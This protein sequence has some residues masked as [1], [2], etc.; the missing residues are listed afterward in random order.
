M[1]IMQKIIYLI[2]L[3]IYEFQCVSIG[4]ILHYSKTKPMD[5]TIKFGDF[6]NCCCDI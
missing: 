2:I 4:Y 3:F 6:Y 1:L 5:K